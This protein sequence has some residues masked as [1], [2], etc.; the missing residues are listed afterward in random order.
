MVGCLSARREAIGS[1]IIRANQ[2]P[3]RLP[4]SP[5]SRCRP[6]HWQA[7]S[8]RLGSRS[9]GATIDYV[10]ILEKGEKSY[11]AYVP[12]LP[13]CVAVGETQEEA[14]ELIREAIELHIEGLKQDGL[15]VPVLASSI[16]TVRVAA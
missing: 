5:A 4:A 9:E 16:R 14:M 3:L 12:D 8:G 6:V 11:G 15:P 10:V 7:H 13:G 1:T 2:E